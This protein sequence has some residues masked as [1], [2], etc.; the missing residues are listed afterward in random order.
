MS[1]DTYLYVLDG[2]SLEN[3]TTWRDAVFIPDDGPL[4]RIQSD[5]WN[6][7]NTVDRVWI[8]QGGGCEIDTYAPESVAFVT[9]L[10]W[11]APVLTRGVAVTALDYM[12]MRNHSQ[13]GTHV[14]HF[15]EGDVLA[16][17]W[18]GSR[19]NGRFET[20]R[21]NVRHHTRIVHGRQGSPRIL[22]FRGRGVGAA[23]PVKQFLQRNMGKRVI[24]VTV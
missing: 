16:V 24:P 2:V 4:G 11:A 7:I 15:H 9:R 10:F 20:P 5:M 14:E 8:G 12:S 21:H 1:A 19:K 3:Y 23:R 13:Y 6:M 18:S 17:N 22:T